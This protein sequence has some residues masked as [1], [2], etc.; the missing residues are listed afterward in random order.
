MFILSFGHSKSKNFSKALEIANDIGS[1]MEKGIM[2][3]TFHDYELLS[4]HK[5][6]NRFWYNFG[7]FVKSSLWKINTLL[8]LETLLPEAEQLNLTI[9]TFFDKEKKREQVDF[10]PESIVVDNINYIIHYNDIVKPANI[11]HIP[12]ESIG[13]K[14]DL[15]S[16]IPLYCSN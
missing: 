6:S 13:M 1:V 15:L 12:T 5:R 16:S 7:G 11:R 9:C 4:S 8:I 10:L 14:G 2:T 3:I